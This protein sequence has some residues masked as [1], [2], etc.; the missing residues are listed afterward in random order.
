MTDWRIVEAGKGEAPTLVEAV[1]TYNMHPG[2]A[3]LLMRGPASPAC[4]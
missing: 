3:H 1:R 2:D 4:W